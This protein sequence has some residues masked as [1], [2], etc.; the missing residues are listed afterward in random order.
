MLKSYIRF[1]AM[2]LLLWVPCPAQIEMRSVTGVVT[3]K[4]G[5]TLPGAALQLENTVTFSI[6]SYITTK[7]L[8]Q[9]GVR[10]EAVPNLFCG[11]RRT[12]CASKDGRYHFNNLA[13]SRNSTNR[14]F[15]AA[16]LKM[17]NSVLETAM[18]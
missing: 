12:L 17:T 13:L 7:E 2:F 6:M 9:N 15:Q 4:R 14:P 8:A 18:R 10:R 3:D 11:A 5:N 1:W 16:F